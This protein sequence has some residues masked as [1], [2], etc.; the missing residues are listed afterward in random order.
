MDNTAT[1]KAA[2]KWLSVPIIA[3]ITQLLCR[4]LTL[5]NEYL[6]QENELLKS[7]IKKWIVLTDA[8]LRISMNIGSI[9]ELIIGFPV[10]II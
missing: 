2:N 5:Q 8:M 1:Q 6:R 3:S 4:E 7:K 10:S 9:R